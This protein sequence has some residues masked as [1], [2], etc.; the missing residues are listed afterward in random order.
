MPKWS[1]LL[2]ADERFRQA[3]RK[4]A[5]TRDPRAYHKALGSMR[6]L[7]SSEMTDRWGELE[8]LNAIARRGL[9]MQAAI[10]WAE[11]AISQGFAIIMRGQEAANTGTGDVFIFTSMHDSWYVLRDEWRTWRMRPGFSS[12]LTDIRDAYRN[13]RV[14]RDELG[15]RTRAGHFIPVY[16]NEDQPGINPLDYEH[17]RTAQELKPLIPQFAAITFSALPAAI[18]QHIAGA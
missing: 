16:G 1:Y 7:P 15:L 5:E 9:S 13:L 4:A 12:I 11:D 6:R 8:V 2:E 10:R 17:R 18:K 14:M 3:I